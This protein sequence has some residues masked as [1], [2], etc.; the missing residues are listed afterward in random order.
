MKSLIQLTLVIALIFPMACATLDDS[1]LS[2][3]EN[4]RPGQ[5]T[6]DS[7]SHG[8]TIGNGE[9][10]S[11][12]AGD[13]DVNPEPGSTEN[14]IDE[15]DSDGD[16][17]PD[18]EDNCPT[19]INPGQQ[20]SNEDGQG[21]ACEISP[22][23]GVLV[24]DN[25]LVGVKPLPELDNTTP[26]LEYIELLQ[27]I[28]VNFSKDMTPVLVGGE[29]NGTS[30]S[31]TVGGSWGDAPKIKMIGAGLDYQIKLTGCTPSFFGTVYEPISNFPVSAIG[32]KE[33]E[34]GI[35]SMNSEGEM[36]L[37]LQFYY[38]EEP[39]ESV[40]L[41]TQCTLTATSDGQTATMQLDINYY[42]A[43]KIPT[44]VTGT[45]VEDD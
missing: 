30:I 35:G 26:G 21:D 6:V 2:E 14:P 40:Q 20:D 27:I 7:D 33:N 32:F 29:V 23:V 37:N 42:P 1:T 41:K 44:V 8:A 34:S 31:V 11:V 36:A 4:F 45:T 9:S 43:D 39:T 13:P 38:W 15:E 10:G 25:I 22:T 3:F 16:G 24:N 18:G 19:Q 28:P 12:V 17:I 5:A